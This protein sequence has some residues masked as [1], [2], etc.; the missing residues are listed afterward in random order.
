MPAYKR[1]DFKKL[2]EVPIEQIC[3]ILG[4][5]LQRK[6]KQLRGQ[7]TICNHT[8]IRCFTVTPALS[9][10]WCFGHCQAGGDGLA[11][12]AAVRQMTVYQA[13]CEL[14]RILKLP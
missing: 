6:G 5:E 1:P 14:R 9:R 10:W 13:A 11:L 2:R 3:E 12:Y 8:S 4:L 7:C